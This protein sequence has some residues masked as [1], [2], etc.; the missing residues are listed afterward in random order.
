MADLDVFRQQTRDWLEENCPQSMRTPQRSDN[1]ACWGGRNFTFASEDQKLWLERMAA[2]GWTAPEWP[3]EYGGGG[4][5]QQEH[6][7]LREE[8]AR[9]NARPPLSSFGIW[10]IGPAILKFGS[11]ELKRQHL[12]PIIRGEIRWCQ[13]YSEPGA[14]S[15]LAGLQTRAEDHGDHFIVNGQ[16][17]WTS[18]ADKADWM[19]C[20]VRTNPDAK[21]QLGI[22]LVL[23][24]MTTPG[25]STRPIKL[26]SG[27]SPFCETFLDNVRVEKNQVVGEIN[28]GWTIAKYL[29]THEREMIGGMGRTAAGQKSLPQIAVDAVGLEDGKLADGML[30]GEL[31]TWD[32]DAAAFALTAERVLDEAKA[33]Q[34]V[35]AA[36]AMLKYYGTELNKRR[37]E[38]MVALHGSDG[39]LWEG[40]ASREGAIARNW[41]RSKGN[42]IEGGTSEVQ[43]NVIARNILG[44]Q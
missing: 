28:A 23:F 14:G 26:I 9:I 30:R 24:D 15:D 44:L 25:V 43:L 22:S 40:E 39:L 8:M 2:R 17:I 4:L 7:V 36:S 3:S 16:K 35:G 38:L 20:L 21:K 27:S 12:P 18:Y 29:L 32:L 1:D 6:K 19:F 41:L 33:G 10:M 34:G 5:S 13:G 31:A 42:S 11:E 37:Q